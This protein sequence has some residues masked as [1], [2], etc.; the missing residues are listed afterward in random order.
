LGSDGGSGGLKNPFTWRGILN[1]A[2]VNTTIIENQ[3]THKRID[4]DTT[5]LAAVLSGGTFHVPVAE[6][7]RHK[8]SIL[9]NGVV[10]TNL[11]SYGVVRI[12]AN[13]D[14]SEVFDKVYCGTS[15]A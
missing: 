5:R 4:F 13:R 8:T 7:I 10:H 12:I 9:A 6:A 2:S 1:A 15:V 14:S 3:K 11:Y